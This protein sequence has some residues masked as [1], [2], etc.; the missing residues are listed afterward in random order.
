LRLLQDITTRHPRRSTRLEPSSRKKSQANNSTQRRNETHRPRRCRIPSFS[1]HPCA[2]QTHG[3]GAMLYVPPIHCRPLTNRTRRHARTPPSDRPSLPASRCL[4]ATSARLHND[5]SG[6]DR[7]TKSGGGTARWWWWCVAANLESFTRAASSF[8]RARDWLSSGR[9]SQR[10]AWH[11][12]E[13]VEKL[14]QYNTPSKT[15]EEYTA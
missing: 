11:R 7:P 6:T 9:L 5:P 10:R 2:S 13:T 3:R 12:V 1:G 8:A 4:P 15:T 14:I